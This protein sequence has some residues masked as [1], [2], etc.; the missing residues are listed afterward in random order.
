MAG[1]ILPISD[2]N[3]TRIRP[4]HPVPES[5]NRDISSISRNSLGSIHTQ[6]PIVAPA[7]E[8]KVDKDENGSADISTG[9]AWQSVEVTQSGIVDKPAGENSKYPGYP[10]NEEDERTGY[11]RFSGTGFDPTGK[12][13]PQIRKMKVMTL[14]STEGLGIFI[15]LSKSATPYKFELKPGSYLRF[16]CITHL[17]ATVTLLKL[18][19]CCEG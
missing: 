5:P 17:T 16:V 4:A 3:P 18:T 19:I 1:P 14:G 2:P 9:G 13:W 8:S 10:E 12:L 11:A 15:D 6:A 7:S